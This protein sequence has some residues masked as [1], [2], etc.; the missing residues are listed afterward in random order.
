M[1]NNF[2]RKAV[3]SMLLCSVSG[4]AQAKT[5][6]DFIEGGIQGDTSEVMMGELASK[7]GSSNAVKEFGKTLMEDHGRAKAEKIAVAQKIGAKVPGGP[8]KDAE[9]AYSKLSKMSGAAFDREFAMHMTMDHKQDIKEF[10]EESK[11][12]H[13]ETSSLAMMQLPTLRKHLEIAQSLQSGR[14]DHNPD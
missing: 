5:P 1:Q 7:K 10:E 3:A 9:A 4:L 8:K 6:K 2:A 14:A 11:A 12:G 13:T